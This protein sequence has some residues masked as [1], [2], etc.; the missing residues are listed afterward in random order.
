MLLIPFFFASYAVEYFVIR[1]LLEMR[2]DTQPTLEYPRVR[3]A[4]RDA[5]LVTYGAMFVGTSIWLGFMFIHR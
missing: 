4:I 5:N 1:L 3:V 2:D